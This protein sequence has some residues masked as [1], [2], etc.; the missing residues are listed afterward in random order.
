M[1]EVRLATLNVNG[2]RDIKKRGMLNELMKQKNLD[3]LL[4]QETHSGGG[5]AADW[6]K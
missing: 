1:S 2:A 5:N 4:L 6:E 3:I